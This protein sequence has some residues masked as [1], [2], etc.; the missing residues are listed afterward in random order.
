MKWLNLFFKRHPE[1]QDLKYLIG[2][3]MLKGRAARSVSWTSKIGQ[4]CSECGGK[5]AVQR[6]LMSV[7]MIGS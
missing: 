4:I 3:Q 5:Y 6:V 7:Q 1:F 2:H